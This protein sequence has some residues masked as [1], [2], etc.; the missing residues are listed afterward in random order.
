MKKA[1]S[2]MMAA[3]AF[4]ENYGKEPLFQPRHGKEM[5]KR[6]AVIQFIRDLRQI[7][8]PGYFGE[9]SMRKIDSEHFATYRINHLYDVLKSRDCYLVYGRGK[10][11]RRGGDR[12]RTYLQ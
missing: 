5:P 10:D 3:E 6:A 12:G 2:I 7:M 9:D 4:A 8:F 1:E 11:K